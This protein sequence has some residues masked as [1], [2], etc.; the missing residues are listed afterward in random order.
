M[1]HPR[2]G[3]VAAGGLDQPRGLGGEIV[4][5]VGIGYVVGTGLQTSGATIFGAVGLSP[6]GVRA[7]LPARGFGDERDP[8]VE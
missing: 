8:A 3:A 7:A 6:N 2:T 4:R 1:S 5:T